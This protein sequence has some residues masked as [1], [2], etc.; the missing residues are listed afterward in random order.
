MCGSLLSPVR[1]NKY[2]TKRKFSCR[3]KENFFYYL[4]TV[5]TFINRL[6]HVNELNRFF[7]VLFVFHYNRILTSPV[8]S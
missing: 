4:M 2:T 8:F 1:Y 7:L 5:N 3:K 6:F